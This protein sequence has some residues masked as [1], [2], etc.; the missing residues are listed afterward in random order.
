[1]DPNEVSKSV[2]VFHIELLSVVVPGERVCNN[3][4]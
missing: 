2:S 3:Q 4:I 1:M